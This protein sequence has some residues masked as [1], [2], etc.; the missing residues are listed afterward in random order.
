[1]ASATIIIKAAQITVGAPVLGELDAGAGQ[2]ARILL[3]LGLQP[4]EQGERVGRRTGKPADDVAAPDRAHLAGVALDDGRTEADL[5]ISGDHHLVA[6]AHGQNGGAVP[7]GVRGVHAHGR[8]SEVAC[9][10]LK[11]L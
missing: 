8:R 9:S 7:D 11:S 3:Q 6:L 5:P 4:L 1:V 10:C 2:L